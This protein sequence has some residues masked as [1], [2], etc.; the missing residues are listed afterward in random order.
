MFLPLA[1]G[2]SAKRRRRVAV[3]A[4]RDVA[5]EAGAEAELP[6]VELDRAVRER[7]ADP[8]ALVAWGAAGGDRV[9]RLLVLGLAEER[10]LVGEGQ[11]A[12]PAG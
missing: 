2:S 9:P 7:I 1:P 3:G 12:R 4:D 6:G 10:V 11:G 8:R 5:V